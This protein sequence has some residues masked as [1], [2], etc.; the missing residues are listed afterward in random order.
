MVVVSESERKREREREIKESGAMST[1]ART[2]GQKRRRGARDLWEV[3]VKC[4]D[5]CFQHILPR[6]HSN[7]VKFLYGVNTETRKLVRRS[8]RAGDLKK[9]FKVK[10][11]SSISRTSRSL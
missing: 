11:M 1:G 9:G 2:R 6:L 3:I 7:D 10:E 5:I 8:S 4:D